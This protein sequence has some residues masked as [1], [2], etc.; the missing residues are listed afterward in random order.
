MAKIARSKFPVAIRAY[1]CSMIR[2]GIIGGGQLGMMSIE[3]KYPS[4]PVEFAVLEQSINCPAASLANHFIAG[5]L[6]S[7]NDIQALAEQ[8]D[9]ITWEIEHI[10]VDALIALEKKGKTII[11]KPSV[12]KTIQD[13]GIQKQFFTQ[14]NIP[15]APY[16]LTQN[17]EITPQLLDQFPGDKVV[18]KTRTGG[19][20]GKGVSIVAKNQLPHESPFQGDVLV[21]SFIPNALEIAII[22]AIGQ[23]GEHAVYPAIEM[24]F[25]PK[26]N[27]VEF[28]FSPARIDQEIEAKAQEI[29]LK[30]IQKLNSPGLFAVE[31]FLTPDNQILVNEI[32]PRPHNSGHH[33]IEGCHC[34][35]F[36]QFLRILSGAPLGD[37]SLIQPAAMINI[38][39]P[40]NISGPYHLKDEEKLTAHGD[41]FV[42]MYRKAESRPHRKL[43]HATVI[44]DTLETLL[45]KA[46][47][48]RSQLQIVAN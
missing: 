11:P 15:T 47:A 45:P 16:I 13:K 42:H 46:E 34:S 40:E 28:L 30:C 7:E 24:Y 5:S 41:V 6:Q 4:L 23:D 48:L 29:S 18:L 9:V 33:T 25:N 10:N 31:L 3:A 43:G 44:A 14:N 22:V 39:G 37:A 36:E 27:L 12:L 1:L 35:Q 2:I 17:N 8:S 19:Y 20:D 38:V 21:E 32:A 26:S